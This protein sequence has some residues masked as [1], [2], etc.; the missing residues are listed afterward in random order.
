[1]LLSGDK[2]IPI[3]EVK[4]SLLYIKKISLKFKN[5]LIIGNYNT[6]IEETPKYIKFFIVN[7]INVI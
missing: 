5:I 2:I 1:M 4:D 7:K 3:A 6:F